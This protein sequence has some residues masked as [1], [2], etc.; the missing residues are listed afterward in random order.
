MV[1]VERR[2]ITS[3]IG[4]CRFFYN[5]N[6]ESPFAGCELKLVERGL[7]ILALQFFIRALAILPLIWEK[8]IAMI[9]VIELAISFILWG[10]LTLLGHGLP[11]FY[12]SFLCIR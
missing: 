8:G 11:V 7:S 10:E 3:I 4:L 1:V 2:I 12:L 6:Y 9:S 5:V